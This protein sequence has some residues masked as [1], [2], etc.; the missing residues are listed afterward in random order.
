MKNSS[1]EGFPRVVCFP[2]WWTTRTRLAS[3]CLIGRRIRS[4]FCDKIFLYWFVLIVY[5]G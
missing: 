5:A 3:P 1:S 4:L 2:F